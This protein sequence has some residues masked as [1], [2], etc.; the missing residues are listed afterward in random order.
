MA[1][2]G[3]HRSCLK[4]GVVAKSNSIKARYCTSNFMHVMSIP[5]VH[6]FNTNI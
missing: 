1:A 4:R 2:M 6:E 5:H 3:H